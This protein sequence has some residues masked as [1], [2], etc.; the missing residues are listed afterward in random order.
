MDDMLFSL[1][2]GMSG[3]DRDLS[4]WLKD[5]AVRPAPFQ[6]FDL[7]GL[8]AAH[9]TA[10]WSA[11]EQ[12]SVQ[13]DGDDVI[14]RLLELK[15]SLAAERS[16]PSI[17]TARIDLTEIW[18]KR[19]QRAFTL[20]SRDEIGERLVD[21]GSGKGN[22]A[23]IALWARER[24]PPDIDPEV[25][26]LRLNDEFAV[27]YLRLLAAADSGLGREVEAEQWIGWARELS[28]G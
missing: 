6:D 20:P 8:S 9:Q 27:R 11:V 22:P 18:D 24:L 14:H 21:I 28:L 5:V 1:G 2:E 10:F 25:V 4:N 26:N 12:L 19:E 13:R 23:D 3:A 16:G 7:R 15:A 17:G